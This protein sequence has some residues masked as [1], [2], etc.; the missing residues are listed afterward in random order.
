MTGILIKE[1]QREICHSD[2]QG[3]GYMKTEADAGDMHPQAKQS[4]ELPEAGRG[5]EG[6]SPRAFRGSPAD[7]LVLDFSTPQLWENKF[8]LF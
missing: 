8:L 7:V 6:F 5:K 1:R 4:L 3:E 2:M